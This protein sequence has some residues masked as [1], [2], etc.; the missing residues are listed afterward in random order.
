MTRVTVF[1]AG[2]VGRAIV[3]DLCREYDVTAVD[4]SSAT[5]AA[6]NPPA[7]VRTRVVD[8]QTPGAIPDAA[9]QADLVVSAVPGHI[10]CQTLEAL[11][12]AGRNVVDIS[13]F[14]EESLELDQLAR[15]HGVTAAVDC[16]VAPGMSH[17]LAGAVGRE[18]TID[19]YECLVGGLPKA[20]TSFAQYK[21]PFSPRDVIEEYLR[22]ARYV[23]G[24]RLV[25]MPALSDLETVE[26]DGVGTL[27]A[28][29]TDGLRTLLRT[30]PIPEMRE[31]TLRY[32]GHA[33]VIQA[34]IDEGAFLPARLDETCARLFPEWALQPGDEEFTVMRVTMTG[35]RDGTGR[36]VVYS[37]YDETDTATGLTSMARTTG[38]TATAVAH[39][40][41]SGRL[42]RPGV[43]PPERVGMEPYCLD[44]VLADLAA[45]GVVYRRTDSLL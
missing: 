20:R 42:A 16:G 7:P 13:F 38:F 32:P 1:G 23:S 14:P 39:L 43:W 19:R 4:R 6:L 15:D 11:I 21:A 18:M 9:G 36:K 28:F 30:M 25:T 24:G 31:K 45:R 40:V 34:L 27:E 41:L 29:D 10:G 17:M 22:P 33:R 37:L 26:I 3:H 44:L 5:L 8:L 35:R 2:L 12:R